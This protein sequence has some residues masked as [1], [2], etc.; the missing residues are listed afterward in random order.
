MDFFKDEVESVRLF[1]I[2]NELYYVLVTSTMV[3]RFYFLEHPSPGVAGHF[4]DDL[5]RVL[6]VGPHVT[7]RPDARV[8]ALSQDLAGKLVVVVES[9]GHE[10][11]VGF[12]LLPAT[13]LGLFLSLGEC[14]L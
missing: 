14:H 12:F 3:E 1:K 2:L 6:E 9:R 5:H 7:A 10:A 4:V 8:R 11:G 13:G